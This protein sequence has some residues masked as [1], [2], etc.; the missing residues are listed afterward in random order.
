M[1]QESNVKIH[2]PKPWDFKLSRIPQV[3]MIIPRENEISKLTK[4]TLHL[5]KQR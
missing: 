3:L 5:F 2:H 1:H 4:A